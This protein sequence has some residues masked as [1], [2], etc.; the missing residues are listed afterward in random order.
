MTIYL[1][2]IARPDNLLYANVGWKKAYTQIYSYTFYS[3][4]SVPSIRK[5]GPVHR[6][7]CNPH[8]KE[9]N[10]KVPQPTSIRIQNHSPNYRDYANK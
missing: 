2:L 1:A 8:G 10:D 5:F 6:D 7:S 3:L 4:I 9:T